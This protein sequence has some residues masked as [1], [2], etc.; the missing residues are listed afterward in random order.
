MR[1]DRD[2]TGERNMAKQGLMDVADRLGTSRDKRLDSVYRRCKRLL[3]D[4]EL[5]EE[6]KTRL[7]NEMVEMLVADARGSRAGRT[8]AWIAMAII[9]VV[10]LFGGGFAGSDLIFGDDEGDGGGAVVSDDCGD[11]L[12]GGRSLELVPEGGNISVYVGGQKSAEACEGVE[13][14]KR[15]QSG[16][17]PVGTV[18]HLGAATPL[19]LTRKGADQWS[20]HPASGDA[21]S[22]EQVELGILNMQDEAWGESLLPHGECFENPDDKSEIICRDNKWYTLDVGLAFRFTGAAKGTEGWTWDLEFAEVPEGRGNKKKSGSDLERSGD[23][24]PKGGFV[25]KSAN[26]HIVRDTARIT[27]KSWKHDYIVAMGVGKIGYIHDRC[28]EDTDSSC[29]D[30]CVQPGSCNLQ[31]VNNIRILVSRLTIGDA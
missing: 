16:C 23:I 20:A 15:V 25:T 4:A 9:G 8:G 26:G 12:T 28:D 11:P 19:G 27:D 6:A 31:Q 29:K 10:A 7:A 22:G 30:E 17:E 3:V 5:P 21:A 14:G 18:A 1:E 2:A 24:V 13:A